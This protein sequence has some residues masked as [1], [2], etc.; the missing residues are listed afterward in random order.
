MP[1]KINDGSIS[2]GTTDEQI[3]LA[4]GNPDSMS[5]NVDYQGTRECWYYED[6]CLIFENGTLVSYQINRKC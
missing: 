4:C 1:D 2:I 5:K 3:R 6:D